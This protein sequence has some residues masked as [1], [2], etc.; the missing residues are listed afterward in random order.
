MPLHRR[1]PVALCAMLLAAHAEAAAPQ[2]RGLASPRQ[3]AAD[4]SVTVLSTDFARP[5]AI[6]ANDQALY[7]FDYGA[8]QLKQF[9]LDGR[10]VRAIGRLGAGPGEFRG[11]TDL[12]SAPSGRIFVADPQNGRISIFSPDGEFVGAFA[13]GKWTQ[14]ASPRTDSLLTLFNAGDSAFVMY[15][16]SQRRRPLALPSGYAFLDT[17]RVAGDRFAVVDRQGT[18]YAAFLYSGVIARHAVSAPAVILADGVARAPW[19]TVVASRVR[20]PEG[21]QAVQRALPSSVRPTLIGLAT[22]GT[23]LV[24]LS[25]ADEGAPRFLDIYDA[26]SL[27]Y[28]C[29]V[30]VPGTVSRI[31]LAG[32][33]LVAIAQEPESALLRN[34]ARAMPGTDRRCVF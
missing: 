5:G 13:P 31:A 11:V 28:A 2:A 23:R 33:R 30:R 8:Q 18:L 26:F 9:T 15:A 16:G 25:W 14:R 6:T 19:P 10:L 3:V 1:R 22:D 34:T 7:V 12:Q 24:T 20:T 4:A 17:A 27:E 29:S 21:R 32:T